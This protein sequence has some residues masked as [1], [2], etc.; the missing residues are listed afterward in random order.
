MAYAQEAKHIRVWEGLKQAW[1]CNE[2][3]LCTYSMQGTKLS[4][5]EPQSFPPSES[6]LLGLCADGPNRS[7]LST[8][9]IAV[10]AAYQVLYIFYFIILTPLLP[11]TSDI[12]VAWSHKASVPSFETW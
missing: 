2:Y 10:A 7:S 1:V 11:D 3:L 6:S 9:S 12:L 4:L 8:I 5:T